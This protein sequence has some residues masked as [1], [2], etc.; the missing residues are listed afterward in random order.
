[1]TTLDLGGDDVELYYEEYGS[2]DDVAL[3]A[4]RS[5]PGAKL[6]LYQDHSHSL[7]SEAPERLVQEV[8]VFTRELSAG[9]WRRAT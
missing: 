8:V 5:V 3:L 4:A 9:A 2:G 1:M 7:A 6:V